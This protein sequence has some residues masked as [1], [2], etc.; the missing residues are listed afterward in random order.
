MKKKVKK[1]LFSGILLLLTCSFSEG[2]ALN[3]EPATGAA[4]LR[5]V[6]FGGA[7]IMFAGKFGGEI[8]RKE[9]ARHHDLKVDG[10]ATGSRI[11]TFTLDVTKDGKTTSLETESNVLTKE[12]VSHLTSLMPGDEFE[13]R[14]TKA[15]LPNGKDVVDVQGRKFVVV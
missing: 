4:A 1:F 15:F 12:M 14:N 11:F 9:I 5:E 7:Y 10:C 8:T 3:P 2:P 13:F 6:P